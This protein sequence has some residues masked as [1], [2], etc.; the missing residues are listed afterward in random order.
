MT[1]LHVWLTVTM[2]CVP[3]GQHALAQQQGIWVNQELFAKQLPTAQYE[4]I[5]RGALAQC[6]ADG[7]ITVERALPANVDCS[8][9]IRAMGNWSPSS[10]LECQKLQEGRT[11]QRE[12]MFQDIVLGCM[13]KQGWLF[14]AK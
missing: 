2:L 10:Y 14:T 11:A 1:R 5:G 6:R 12:Q 13:A 4:A 9:I 8:S 3:M 7:Q